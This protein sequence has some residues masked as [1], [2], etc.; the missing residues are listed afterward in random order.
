MCVSAQGGA[1]DSEG[2]PAVKSSDA[3]FLLPAGTI[4]NALGIIIELLSASLGAG[5]PRLRSE[6]PENVPEGEPVRPRAALSCCRATILST[7]V[8]SVAS[9]TLGIHST[10]LPHVRW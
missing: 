5:D 6:P 10:R 4:G 7:T 9:H 2:K 3:A 1:V 8:G